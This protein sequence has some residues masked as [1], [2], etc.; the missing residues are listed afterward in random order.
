M[1]EN[2]HGF[3]NRMNRVNQGH[4][5]NKGGASG[6]GPPHG[7]AHKH[8]AEPTN[9]AGHTYSGKMQAEHDRR[10]EAT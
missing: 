5:H 10:T 9:H 3:T 1:E 2:R 4:D 8:M 7:A 6:G